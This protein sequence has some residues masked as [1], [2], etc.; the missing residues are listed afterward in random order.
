MR[1]PRRR[2]GGEEGGEKG[3]GGERRKGFPLLPSPSSLLLFFQRA[4]PLAVVHIGRQYLHAVLAG[5]ADELG[6]GVEPQRL[7][8]EQAAV[9]AAM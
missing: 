4:I 1:R 8:V 7:A 5:V 3:R 6:G 2:A 9:K